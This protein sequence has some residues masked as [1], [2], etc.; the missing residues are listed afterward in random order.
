MGRYVGNVTRPEAEPAAAPEAA[1]FERERRRLTLLAYRMCGSWGDAED[2]VQAVALEWLRQPGPVADPAAWLTTVTVRRA[3]DALR[4]R[5]REA[6]Y[7]GPWVPEP[8]VHAGPDPHAEA[9]R[10]EALTTAFLML[11]EEL[12]PP[13]RAV[14]V[15]R[16]LGYEHTEIGEVLQISPAAS[17][18][19]HSRGTRRLSELN[20]RDVHADPTLGLTPGADQREAQRLLELFLRAARAGDVAALLGLLHADVV[21]YSDGGGRVR[22]A[23]RPLYGPSNVA[24]FTAGVTARHPAERSTAQLLAVNAGPGAVLTMSGDRHVISLQVRDG[25]I[26]RLFDVANPDKHAGLAGLV[27]SQGVLLLG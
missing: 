24:R 6:S 17:R 8:V 12:T 18:Q 15:L 19:H 11:A 13:Q 9:E 5:R 21:A 23:R 4:A 3:L 25:R 10:T 2:V 27:A 1:A 22:A 16:A 20:G 14:V 26:Y 7:V